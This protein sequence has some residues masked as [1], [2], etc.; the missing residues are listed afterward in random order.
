[1][2]GRRSDM[3][4]CKSCGKEIAEGAVYCPYCGASQRETGYRMPRGRGWP[5]GRILAGFVAFIIIVASLGLIAGGGGIMWAQRNFA[6]PDGYLVS[7]NVRIHTDTYAI[8]SPSFD[9]N[10]DVDLP[11]SFWLTRDLSDIVTLKFV[12]ES[13]DPSKEILIAVASGTQAEL[14]FEGVEYDELSRLSWDYGSWDS[15]EPDIS[16]S[17]HSGGPPDAAPIAISYWDAV[18]TGSGA[19]ELDWE[20]A[21]GSYWILIMNADGSAGV[22]VDVKLGARVPILQTIGNMLIFGGIVALLI[23]AFVIYQWVR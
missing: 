10:A 9:I 5:I 6:D 8:V 18:R 3:P 11:S 2:N 4:Y 22:D 23:G 14:Y 16:Y 20:P 19:Q 7:R 15:D 13:N 12:V 21:W 17:R 1:M